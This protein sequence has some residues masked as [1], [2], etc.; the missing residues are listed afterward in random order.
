MEFH[1]GIFTEEL[2]RRTLLGISNEDV[3]GDNDGDINEAF[4]IEVG[5]IL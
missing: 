1:N 4:I 3:K 2:F 5:Y